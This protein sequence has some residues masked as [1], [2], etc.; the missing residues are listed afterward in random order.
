MAEVDRL[1]ESIAVYPLVVRNQASRPA[2]NR[3]GKQQR[4]RQPKD[5][6]LHVTMSFGAA[7]RLP[8]EDIEALM[9]RAD[10]ALYKAKQNG[11]NRVE[12]AR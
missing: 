9:K 2:D 8:G 4:G 6:V 7:L 11:R 5:K 3:S 1:R 12:R 10:K